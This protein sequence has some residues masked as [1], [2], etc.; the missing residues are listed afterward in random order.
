[1][2]PFIV[3]NKS[4]STNLKYKQV[5]AATLTIHP[6]LSLFFDQEIDCL[7]SSLRSKIRKVLFNPNDLVD[8]SGLTA[9]FFLKHKGSQVILA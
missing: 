1:M 2:S 9:Y 3:S 8:P 4:P 6:E 5:T 7:W